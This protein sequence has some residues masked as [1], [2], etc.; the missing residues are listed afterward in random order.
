MNAIYVTTSG[1]FSERLFINVKWDS[2]NS[3]GFVEATVRVAGPAH[4]GFMITVSVYIEKSE[5]DKFVKQCSSDSSFD[6]RLHGD[7]NRFFMRVHAGGTKTERKISFK[8]RY[9][10]STKIKCGWAGLFTISMVSI[11][12]IVFVAPHGPV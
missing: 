10:E 1:E 6:A 2:S 8:I 3:D 5:M 12:K 7:R 11:E 4:D 9:L